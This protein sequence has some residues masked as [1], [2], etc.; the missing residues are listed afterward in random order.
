MVVASLLVNKV[1]NELSGESHNSFLYGKSAHNQ[2]IE[3][4]WRDVHVKVVFKYKT[5]FKSMEEGG[6]LDINNSVHISCLH[7]TFGQRIQ[8]DLEVWPNAYN[9]HNVLTEHNQTPI[10]LCHSTNFIHSA[11]EVTAI[12]NLFH[13]EATEYANIISRSP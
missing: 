3:C 7:H 4:L 8:R 13:R 10:E 11:L 5:I 1:V 2:R 9:N 6:I 12:Q